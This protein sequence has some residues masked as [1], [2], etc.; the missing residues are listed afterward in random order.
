MAGVP[1]ISPWVWRWFGRYARWYVPRHFHA[2]R[3][4][5]DAPPQHD[6]ADGRPLVVYLNHPSWWDP[7]TCLILA[8][9]F[10]PRRRHYAPIDA[11][12]LRRYP[13]FAKLGFFGVE[14]EDTRRGGLAFLR[15]AREILRDP[16]AALWVTAQGQ[17][18]DTRARPIRLGPGLARLAAHVPGATI[19]PLA[20]EYPFWSEKHPEALT[21]F[22][23]PVD[24]AAT[25]SAFERELERAADRL[26]VAAQARDSAA[27]ETILGGR[28]GVTLPYDLWRRARALF[29]GR[30][31]QSEHGTVGR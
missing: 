17:F 8:H 6:D 9:H 15:T 4:L 11:A 29:A 2:V 21:A 25:E 20:I 19:L 28:A 1:R 3:M 7:M 14:Q 30:R 22:G 5:R 16:A 23:V 13:F 12:A 10:W 26:A 24:P 18:T 31:Y 27:F